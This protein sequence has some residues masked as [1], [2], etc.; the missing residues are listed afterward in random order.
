MAKRQQIEKEKQSKQAIRLPKWYQLARR[1]RTTQVPG[2]YR[3]VFDIESDPQ[4]KDAPLAEKVEIAN[5]IRKAWFVQK[6]DRAKKKG[7]K[8]EEFEPLT[9]EDYQDGVTYINNHQ[10]AKEASN[11][12]YMNVLTTNVL[13]DNY[14]K[15]INKAIEHPDPTKLIS[16]TRELRRMNQDYSAM[17]ETRPRAPKA[18]KN[19]AGT[20]PNLPNYSKKEKE[21]GEGS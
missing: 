6:N 4:Y 9:A 7:K 17:H 13:K 8:P 5:E 12:I 20:K 11:L 19:P 3:A 16:V 21:D 1:V 18:P 14:E 15:I 10:R 2:Q